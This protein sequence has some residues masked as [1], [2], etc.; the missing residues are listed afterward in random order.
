MISVLK[1]EHRF[2]SRYTSPHCGEEVSLPDGP[3]V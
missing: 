3:E 2:L 1:M